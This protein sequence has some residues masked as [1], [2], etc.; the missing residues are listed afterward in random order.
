MREA[1]LSA[2]EKIAA[3]FSGLNT[4][5]PTRPNYKLPPTSSPSSAA[6]LFGIDEQILRSNMTKMVCSFNVR[7]I[8]RRK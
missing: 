3:V 1:L 2:K 8:Y 7:T 4:V 6:A 5:M